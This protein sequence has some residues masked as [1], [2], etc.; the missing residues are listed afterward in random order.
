MQLGTCLDIRRIVYSRDYNR[1]IYIQLPLLYMLCACE[2]MVWDSKF[3][4]K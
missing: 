4:Q 2:S 1:H 3:G